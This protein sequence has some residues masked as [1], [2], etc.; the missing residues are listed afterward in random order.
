MR[1]DRSTGHARIRLIRDVPRLGIAPQ[2]AESGTDDAVL[3]V[4]E[5][6]RPRRSGLERLQVRPVSRSKRWWVGIGG[7]RRGRGEVVVGAV[8]QWVGDMGLSAGGGPLQGAVGQGGQR[9]AGCLVD[10]SVVV[11]AQGAQ[12]GGAAGAVGPAGGVVGVAADGGGA[13]AGEA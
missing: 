5:T 3:A 13:A 8:A 1:A 10:E 6:P 4:D 9:P 11:A 7:W 12:V 2:E